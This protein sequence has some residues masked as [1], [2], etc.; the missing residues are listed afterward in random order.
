MRRL[1]TIALC[2]GVVCFPHFAWCQEADLHFLIDVPKH[3]IT[4]PATELEMRMW[5]DLHEIVLGIRA[6]LSGEIRDP[7]DWHRL[8][9]IESTL[10]TELRQ[11]FEQKAFQAANL[12]A[13]KK[14]MVEM[15]ESFGALVSQLPSD[16][17][18]G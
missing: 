11:E 6:R 10:E 18:G 16:T 13:Y 7:I 8:S 5:A 14:Q 15:E 4:R 17:E 12:D 2:T 1:F 3:R 9:E